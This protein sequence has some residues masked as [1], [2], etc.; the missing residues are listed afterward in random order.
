MLLIA[1]IFVL[2]GCIEWVSAEPRSKSRTASSLLLK[3]KD[4]DRDWVSDLDE[5][6]VFRT[7]P[8][9]RDS[10]RDG[11][12]DGFEFRKRRGMFLK[13]YRERFDRDRD[14]DGLS[15][16]E[17]AFWGTQK[18]NPDTDGDGVLDGNEDADE[19]GISNEDED[20][21]PGQGLTREDLDD[22]GNVATPTPIPTATPS[23]TPTPI[24][25]ATPTPTPTGSPMPTV[26]PT[27]QNCFDHQGQ[28]S[29][30]GIPDGF[31][32]NV[33]AG[34]AVWNSICSTCHGFTGRP[35]RSFPEISAALVTVV[36]M[37]NLDLTVQQQADVTAYT[38]RP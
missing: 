15:D 23:P 3:K 22:D 5:R 30:F 8:R 29:C 6:R 20:D 24:N 19:N 35:P 32:G 34:Q 9:R 33:N 25:G 13:D 12:I 10:D 28:T 36:D 4:T 7:N 27:P 38:N 18:N 1:C 2:L 14:G 17:E 21:R 16:E 26:T 31:S 37:L 11:V